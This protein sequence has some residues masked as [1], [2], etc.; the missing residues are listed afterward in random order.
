M[1]RDAAKVLIGEHFSGAGVEGEAPL[2][3]TVPAGEWLA[4]AR[5]AKEELGCRF[6]NPNPDGELS[7]M[8]IYTVKIPEPDQTLLLVSGILGLWWLE[9]FRSRPGRNRSGR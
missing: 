2:V 7:K 3:V 5:F 6:F 4:F 9:R 8:D 1:T